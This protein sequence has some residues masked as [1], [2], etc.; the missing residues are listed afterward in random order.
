MLPITPIRERHDHQREVF[1]GGIGNDREISVVLPS[2]AIVALPV[3]LLLATLY[4]LWRYARRGTT[5]LHR[6][7]AK[8]NVDR[9]VQLLL[10]SP[11]SVNEPD[12]MGFSPLQYAAYWGQT[13]TARLLLDHGADMTVKR[14]FSPLHHAAAQG[15]ESVARLLLQ[16]GFDVNVRSPADGS[17]PL[18]SAAINRR[19]DMAR[20]LLDHGAQVDAAT[21]SGWTACHFAAEKGDPATMQVL[22]EHQADWQAANAGEQ[23]PLEVALANGHPKIIELVRAHQQHQAGEDA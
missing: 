13:E 5:P 22:L 17:T 8:G 21:N 9:L 19:A 16:R 7:A 15:H 2:W 4:G 20:F 11:R 3:V 10:A 23:S 18:H 14:R 1:P 12:F 6:A